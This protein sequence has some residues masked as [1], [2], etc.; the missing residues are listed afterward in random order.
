[1]STDGEVTESRR[2]HHRHHVG[3]GEEAIE[4]IV[5]AWQEN[6]PLGS[7]LA[8]AEMNRPPP[9]AS[10][11]IPAPILAGGI[12]RFMSLTTAQVG[13]GQGGS[14]ACMMAMLE[15][16]IMIDIYDFL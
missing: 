10:A 12:G 13:R 15:T 6:H 7:M 14:Y 9:L 16:Y 2:P 4:A 8:A 11:P 5:V 1:M 3:S